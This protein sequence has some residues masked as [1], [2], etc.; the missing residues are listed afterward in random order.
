MPDVYLKHPEKITLW[1]F[2]PKAGVAFI[3]LSIIAIYI[4]NQYKDI[5]ENSFFWIIAAEVVLFCI[6]FLV[7]RNEC[8]GRK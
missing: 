2:I 7:T 1:Y 4:W 3:F 8:Y 5:L 6:C